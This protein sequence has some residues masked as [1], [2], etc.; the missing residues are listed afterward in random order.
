MKNKIDKTALIDMFYVE[1]KPR[2]RRIWKYQFPNGEMGTIQKDGSFWYYN[3][4]FGETGCE[5][6]FGAKQDLIL[7]HGAKVWSE[8]K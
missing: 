4:K 5:S 6:L 8:L 1:S 2:K 3:D 7:I